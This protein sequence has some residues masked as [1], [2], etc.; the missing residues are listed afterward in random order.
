M[1]SIRL[2][3][4]CA[5]H[6]L[7][8]PPPICSFLRPSRPRSP[9]PTPRLLCVHQ[10]ANGMSA[11]DAWELCG[12]PNGATGIQ[13]IRKRAR[14]LKAA[15]PVPVVTPA[16]RSRAETPAAAPPA[17]EKPARKKETFRK[18]SDQVAKLASAD[19]SVKAAYGKIYAAAT[20]EWLEIVSKSKNERGA[21]SA[22]SVAARYSAQLPAECKRR[23]TARS[24]YNAIAQNRVNVAPRNPG[25]RAKVPSTIVQASAEFC[26]L[27]QIAGNE[28]KP[29]QV[30]QSTLAAVKGTMHE[31]HLTTPSQR[32]AFLRRVR[33]EF[34]LATQASVTIDNRRWLWLTSTN[35]ATWFEG[36]IK[37][38][39]EWKFINGIPDNKF[40]VIVISLD[41][42]ARLLNGDESHQ[43]LSNEGEQRGSRAN[44]YVNLSLGRAGKRKVQ[45]QKHATILVWVNYA[46]E[47]GAPHLMLATDSQGAKKGAEE[48]Q[49]AGIR[50]RPEWTFGVPRVCG[51]FGHKTS[52]I[53]EPSFVL[54]EKGG[55]VGGGLEQFVNCQI[56]PAYPNLGPQWKYDKD[57]ELLEGPVFMQLDAGPDRYTECSLAWRAEMWERGLVF[58]PGLPNGTAANQVLDDLFGPYKTGCDQVMDDLVSERI[59]ASH[60]DPSLKIMLDFCDLGRVI[61]GRPEDPVELR[62]FAKSFTPAKILASTAR[63]GL[64]PINL[65]TA[66]N[67]PRVRDDSKDGSRTA[68]HVELRQSNE[69][70]L[71]NLEALG[72]NATPLQVL[73]PVAPPP[74]FVAPPSDAEMRWKAV[75][76][77]GGCAGA[78]WAAVGATAFN[79]PDVIGPALERLQEKEAEVSNRQELRA[80]NFATLRSNV[81]EILEELADNQR[82]YS[83]CTAADLKQLVSFCFQ[84]RGEAGASAHTANKAA[85]LEFLQGMPPDAMEELVESPPCDRSTAVVQ[86]NLMSPAAAAATPMLALA[87]AC[88]PAFGDVGLELPEG[89]E[90]M[91]T[92]SDFLPACLEPL[93][94][95]A[96]ELVGRFILYRWPTR[97]GGWLV[98]EVKAAN[99]DSKEMV[100]DDVANFNV[101]YAADGEEAKH[102]LKL[103]KYAKNAKASTDAWVLLGPASA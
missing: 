26:Q 30:M 86:A 70:T 12:E 56:L 65:R 60:T 41:K 18:R 10:T 1:R 17:T 46:G 51:K 55:M 20:Q 99:T 89:L 77:A 61:D 98:G 25:P 87:L 64:S 15:V 42:L 16:T 47:V 40:E 34:G 31:A 103:K 5:L 11:R 90:I 81:Q 13:N 9:P 28:Q 93:S 101:F 67:H 82:V 69:A 83:E 3:K 32:A 23:I 52:Q 102:C 4:W 79:A 68:E 88:E 57:G 94:E 43:K 80:Q 73:A 29:R 74:S 96:S 54:N 14:M 6:A 63:L 36:Y 92:P 37:C 35:L 44:T 7:A 78:H 53:F 85:C 95:T 24:L 39:A 100:G 91:A 38:L 21:V 71:R 48:S 8:R 62:P 33:L 84:A 45:Y 50:I 59:I 97:I 72:V 58:F 19:A 2:S 66:L 27:Q 49:A 75:K 22:A 76:A